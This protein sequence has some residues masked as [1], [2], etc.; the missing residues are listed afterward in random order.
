MIAIIGGTF[1][2]I[3]F[4]H[5]RSALDL[6]QVLNLH[7]VRFI[8]CSQPPHR[9]VPIALP[10]QRLAMLEAAIGDEAGLVSDD[11]ELGRDG[12]SYT[13]DTL[14]AIRAEVGNKMPL[15]LVVGMDSFNGFASWHRWREL[16][17]LCHLVVTFRPGWSAPQSGEI[18]SLVA[19][20][21]VSDV[22]ELR[23]RPGGK[24]IFCNVT[25]LD[26]SAS[27]IRSLIAA[28][29]SPRYLVPDAVLEYIRRTSLYQQ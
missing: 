24:L 10:E 15:C 1:D 12:P 19:E 5:L 18:A 13:V 21:Q 27:R 3:H 9:G 25:Q 28:G 22:N 4:G 17:N 16:I 23:T 6:L 7:E 29:K 14:T 8:P 2:P 11:C 20:R 26:I